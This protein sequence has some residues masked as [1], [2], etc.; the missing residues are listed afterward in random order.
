MIRFLLAAGAGF[1]L[2]SQLIDREL[3]QEIPSAARDRLLGIQSS[4]QRARARVREALDAA[5]DATH[6]AE[7]ELQQEYRRRLEY[8]RSPRP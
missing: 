7:R 5:S 1:A 3:P 4:L 6:E 2:A 8:P